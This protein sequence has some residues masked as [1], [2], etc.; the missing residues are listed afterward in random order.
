MSAWSTSNNLNTARYALAGCGT[1]TAGLSFG[2]FTDTY[3]AVT[4]E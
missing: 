2:G 1:Q 4:E 3:S